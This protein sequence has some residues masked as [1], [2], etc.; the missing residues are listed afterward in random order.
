METFII[1][2]K[3]LALG[4]PLAYLFICFLSLAMYGTYMTFDMAAGMS[5]KSAFEYEQTLIPWEWLRRKEE[6]RI[7]EGR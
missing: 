5:E 4:I 3:L 2:C 7:S 1:L 6:K